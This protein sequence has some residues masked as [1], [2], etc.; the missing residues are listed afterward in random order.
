MYGYTEA[1]GGGGLA[2]VAPLSSPAASGLIIRSPGSMVIGQ[3]ATRGGA[4]G[5]A[6]GAMGD[7][8]GPVAPGGGAVTTN[9]ANQLSSWRQILD[10]HNSPAPWVLLM[11]LFV[12]GYVHISYRKGRLHAGGGL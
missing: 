4:P 2:A 9:P 12:Y 3:Q 1:L 7:F 11:L 5:M 10:F 6:V 8:G